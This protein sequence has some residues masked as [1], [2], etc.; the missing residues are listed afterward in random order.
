MKT[1]E[2]KD[3]LFLCQFFYPEFV[4]SATLPFDTAKALKD[5]GLSVEVICGYPKEYSEEKNVK[6][7]ENKD[8]ISIH[9][10]K[11]LQLKRSNFLGRIINYFSFTFM[12]LTRIFEFKKYKAVIVYSNPPVLPLVAVLAKKMFGCKLVF[13][14]YDLY[15]EIALKT[16]ALNNGGVITR[17]MNLINN[18]VYK[19]SDQ[20]VALDHKMKEFIIQNRPIKSENVS[21]IPNWYEDRINNKKSDITKNKFYSLYKSKVVI[22]YLGN[23][24]ICQDMDTI[25]E[26][27]R[28]LKNDEDIHFLLAGHG[29]KSDRLKE[30]IENE[31]LKNVDVFG[32]LK[33]KD[34]IDALEIS[35]CSLVSLA[36][37]L[38]GLCVPSKTYANMMA[39]KPIIAIMEDSDLVEDIKS[40]RIGFSISNGESLLLSKLLKN[41][42]NNRKDVETMG[43]NSRRVFLEKYEKNVCTKQYVKL[44]KALFSK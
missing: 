5:A 32:F 41:L 39:A 37:G 13:V 22:S 33:G 16:G 28:L 8:G 18:L 34:Y 4:S 35:S 36:P 42:K 21:V 10:L 12:V 40:D 24:G 14:A 11:Y 3:I 23:M 20:V 6:L 7:I 27:I 30:V 9:R 43:I 38:S 19:N 17:F 15:P 44:F 1:N 25:L 31:N 2:N 26:T 29:N